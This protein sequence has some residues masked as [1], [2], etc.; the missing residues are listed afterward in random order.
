M[1]SVMKMYAKLLIA[2][3]NL[4]FMRRHQKENAYF[5]QFS[6]LHAWQIMFKYY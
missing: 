5:S 3:N 1:E 2:L 6:T 4:V